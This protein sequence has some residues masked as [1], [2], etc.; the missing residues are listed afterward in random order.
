[1]DP[2]PNGGFKEIFTDRSKLNE[3][4]G[5]DIVCLDEGIDIIWKE[6]IRLNDEASV[7]VAEAVAIQMAVGKVDPTKE[8]NSYFFGLQIRIGGSGV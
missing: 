7:F 5:S 6:E 3:R 4:V 2:D 8:K 1:M